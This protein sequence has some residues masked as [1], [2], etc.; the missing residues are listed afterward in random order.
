MLGL[1][2]VQESPNEAMVE[3]SARAVDGAACDAVETLPSRFCDMRYAGIYNIV[4]A[5]LA[6]VRIGEDEE[7]DI[8][9]DYRGVEE[10]GR[11]RNRLARV[12]DILTPQI[13]G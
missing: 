6:A 1:E 11:R 3:E 8:E 2:L 13:S 12:G 10:R 4:G 5:G 9:A 7:V